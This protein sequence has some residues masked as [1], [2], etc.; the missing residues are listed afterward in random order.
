MAVVWSALSLP[1]AE[2]RHEKNVFVF[3]RLAP[4]ISNVCNASSSVR[5][6]EPKQGDI[7]AQY[8][9][10][11]PDTH[12][13]IGVGRPLGAR[14]LEQAKQL[15]VI[16][17]VSVGYDNYDLDYL[18]RRGIALTNTP[19]V[20]TETTADLGFALLISAAR[21]V[22][23]LD[24]WVKAGNWKR[25]VDARSSAPTCMARNSASSASAGSAR[26]SPGAAVSASAC[27]CSTTATTASRN[28]NRNSARA[29]SAS[30][31]C[32]ARP[33]SSAWWCRWERRP[34]S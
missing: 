33:I 1:L 8:A 25:T 23:E 28:W 31:N 3:S 4:S 10:A 6:L 24:A 9:A 16:S 30:T 21:L 18:N 27:R 22:A 14:Q 12:G 2:S 32:S 17:S 11:L 26:P 29:S 5:V 34:G 15:E 20:L 13:M 7:D 19:D